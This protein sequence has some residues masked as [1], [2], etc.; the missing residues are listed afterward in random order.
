[1]KLSDR[2]QKVKPS[3]TMAMNS[4]VI[5]LK[6]SGRDVVGFAAGE[7]DFPTWDNV[8]EAAHQS[9]RNGEFKYTPVG[10]TPEMRHAITVKLARDNALDY[11]Q[12]EV[13]ASCGGKHTL[14][15][16]MQALL[17]DGDEVVIPG[18]YWVSYP[19]MV[20]LSGGVPRVLS[21]SEEN[22]F[23][24]SAAELEAA[25]TPATRMVI[26][27]S[28][29]NPTGACYDEAGLR[30]LGAVLERHDCVVLCDDVYEF[31]RYDG[32]RPPHLLTMFPSLRERTVVA[33]SV[34]KTYAMTGWRVGYCAAPANV[35]KAMLTLQ[36]Q[37]TSNPSSIA[38]A[39]AVEALTGPQSALA[40]M[41][42]EFGRR[43]DYVTER[44]NAIDG[45]SVSPPG[46]AFYVFVN[47]RDAFQRAGVADGDAFALAMLDGAS[48]GVVGGNDF[49][50]SDHFRVSYATSMEQLSKGLDAIENW[51]GGL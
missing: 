27:N 23:L 3:S 40:P 26:L 34:S 2:L 16:A 22:G 31:V 12:A 5:E 41:I 42:E 45:L 7:P 9:I 21:A 43:R 39:A 51:L 24:L 25:L 49:G 36:G 29:S 20:A 47:A 32:G 11:S 13:M 4:R 38:Q 8:C 28:P 15:N 50:S 46:G 1:M 17:S 48:V 6:A 30:E 33:N 10:G 18:P 14:Y 37:M 19:D 35:I 44:F